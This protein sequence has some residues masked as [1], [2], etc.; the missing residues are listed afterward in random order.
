MPAPHNAVAELHD[1]CGL[2][3]KECRAALTEHGGDVDAALAALIDAG[4]VNSDQLN[5][6]TVSDELFDRA[7]R[8]QK[9]EMYRKLLEPGGGLMGMIG[10]LASSDGADGGTF[11]ALADTAG[12]LR[13]QLYGN[14]T[15][16][17]LMAED[18]ARQAEKF[19][20][21]KKA[22]PGMAGAKPLT[23]GQLAR[24]M[25]NTQRRSEWLKANPY[26]LKLPPFPPLRRE[27][28]EW[29]GKDVLTAWAGTQERHGGYTSRS[30]RKPSNGSVMIQIPRLG[31]DDANPRPPAPEQVAAYAYLTENQAK[32][33][34]A[35]MKALLAD[36]KKLR[37]GWLKHDP[38]LELPEIETVDD[39][40]KN[41]G[42]GTLHMHDIAR[43]GHAYIGLE[44]GCTWDEE[45]GAGVLLHKGRV[46]DVGQA[47]T[48]FNNHAA[49]KD[50]GKRLK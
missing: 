29:T 33:T 25:A 21:L 9:L 5:P 45:H 41:V 22:M 2:P 26:T 43:A 30:S 10:R 34:D 46:V 11:K 20:K 8:R 47:D 39:M 13:A 44:L 15:A 32:V 6:D 24:S 31:E 40:R 16:E 36:Y 42:L 12:Q 7:A 19:K 17:Q 14:K 35:V 49:I 48:S 38:E 18:E 28:H 4:R 1:K 50:G 23:A 27:M 3:V 37:K